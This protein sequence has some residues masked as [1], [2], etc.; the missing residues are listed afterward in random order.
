MASKIKVDPR[1]FKII[2]QEKLIESKT[3]SDTFT[4][5]SESD[6]GTSINSDAD[7]VKVIKLDDSL[8]SGG[9]GFQQQ[10]Q[11]KQLQFKKFEK[12]L[13][14]PSLSLISNNNNSQSPSI[15]P[16][17]IQPSSLQPSSLQPSS[18][19]PSSLQPSSLQP[20]SLQQQPK[21][22]EQSE[23]QK[24]EENYLRTNNPV[25]NTVQSS[26]KE[27]SEDTSGTGAE[28]ETETGTEID[29]EQE[30]NKEENKTNE[31]NGS[32]DIIDLTKSQL[33]DVLF[34][35]FADST[36]NNI[37]ENIEKMSKLFEAHNQIMEKIL[38]QLVIMNS[39]Y[40]QV[41]VPKDIQTNTK[42]AKTLNEFRKNITESTRQSDKEA[43]TTATLSKPNQ[44]NNNNNNN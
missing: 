37:S 38:N 40:K 43:D 33:H 8:Q 21:Q 24:M 16:S 11:Q 29:S 36:G 39:N 4:S 25:S 19:Q 14:N 30:I 3:E 13:K 32:T 17:S 6:S 41:T 15:Q 27:F 20:S 31:E 22:L 26:F 34:S 12:P 35:I 10:Q 28:T 44:T 5:E 9:R 42:Q 18:L 7:S 2:N 23:K 1:T